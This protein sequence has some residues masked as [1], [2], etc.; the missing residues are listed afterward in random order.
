MSIIG[1]IIECIKISRFYKINVPILIC[2]QEVATIKILE[3][4]KVMRVLKE[5]SRKLALNSK[6]EARTKN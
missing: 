1:N 3:V 4:F 6:S 5:P 2:V